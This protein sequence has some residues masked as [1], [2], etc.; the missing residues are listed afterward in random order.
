MTGTR[1]FG[2]GT[3]QYTACNGLL[4]LLPL[5]SLQLSWLASDQC[6]SVLRF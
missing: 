6:F 3:V 1:L 4:R 5:L 2:P